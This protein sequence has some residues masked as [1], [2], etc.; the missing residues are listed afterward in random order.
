MA[1]SGT[2]QGQSDAWA[3]PVGIMPGPVTGTGM[4]S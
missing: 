1:E 4:S 2:R 3:W